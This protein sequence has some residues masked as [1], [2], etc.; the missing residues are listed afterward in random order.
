MMAPFNASDF[1]ILKK[2]EETEK[3]RSVIFSFDELPDCR[4]D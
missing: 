2:S 3:W 1:M 4:S